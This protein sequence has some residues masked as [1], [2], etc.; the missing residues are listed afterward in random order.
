[1]AL[2]P[3]PSAAFN[4]ISQA[5]RAYAGLMQATYGPEPISDPTGEPAL[6]GKLLYAGE[7]DEP[8][9]ALMVAGNV[10]GA[11]SLAATADPA[12]QK[13]AIRDGVADFLVTSLDEALRILKNEIRKRATVAVCVA[14][15]PDAVEREMLERGVLPDLLAPGMANHP[16]G[17]AFQRQGARV[18]RPNPTGAGTVL[19]AWRVAALPALWLPRLDT[20]ALD[21]M[22]PDCLAPEGAPRRW[23]RL[24]PRYLGR[25]AQGV[26]LL[27]CDEKLAANLLQQVRERV[28]SG[29]IAVPV[30]M[31]IIS[32][33]ESHLHL[34][35]P[36]AGPANQI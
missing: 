9:R 16:A 10:A 22:A 31:Q 36:P 14:A 17:T 3:I 30:E 35:S 33:G 29:E 5:E 25:L 34:F 18:T 21:C 23:L 6:G 8:G 32:G 15:T 12:A 28:A 4:F 26:R 24:A 20:L 7:L 27:R 1:M 2:D 13:Q 19:V 11:A